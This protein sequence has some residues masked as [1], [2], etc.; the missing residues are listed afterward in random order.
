MT[1]IIKTYLI[2]LLLFSSLFSFAQED[3]NEKLALQ[4]Y[5]NQEFEK[6]AELY[7]QLFEDNNKAYYY[8]NY[9]N[10]L[11][12]LKDFSTAEKF[13][14]KLK[15]KTGNIKYYVDLG[16]IYKKQGKKRKA[17]KEFEEALDDVRPVKYEFVLL[18]NTF[19][20]RGLDN[21]AIKTYEKAKKK[22]KDPLLNIDL[23]NL[24]LSMGEYEL[25][26]EEY[27]SLI[28]ENN[29]YITTVRKKFSLILS[30]AG[31][32]KLDKAI[33]SSL[34]KKIDKNPNKT[35]FSELLYWYSIQ[36]KDFKIALIQAKSLD[37]QFKEEGQRVFSL[38]NTLISNKN[39]ELA[40]Q[41]LEY[42]VDLGKRNKY[43]QSAELKLLDVEFK[44]IENTGIYKKEKVNELIEKHKTKLQN[45]GKNANTLNIIMNLA[46]LYSFYSNDNQ[47]A[48]SLLKEVQ[49]MPRVRPDNKAKAKIL[50]ADIMM[51]IGQKWEA[52]LLYKQVEKAHKND[53]LGSEARFKTAKFFYYVGEM[54]W[55]K[56]QLDVL[57]SIPDKL[58]ANDALELALLIQENIN[59]DSTYDALNMYSK[60]ELFVY[61]NKYDKAF[62]KL[63][64]L[65]YLFPTHQIKDDAYYQKALIYYKMKDYKK[66]DSLF[67][68]VVKLDPQGIKSDDAQIRRARIN[69]EIFND[70]Q[71][72]K[73]LYKSIILDY[74][75][76]IYLSEARR[77]F[78]EM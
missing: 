71:K 8:T 26:V 52:S 22:L 6:A 41:A 78:R 5:Q 19:H 57:K 40:Q 3:V 18:A 70:N 20:N 2:F 14:K 68:E 25:M 77:R 72:A 12:E 64:S 76:S 7:Y 46:K 9:L 4:Y 65:I 67:A 49:N 13:V 15:R 29:R 47:K 11:F 42:I 1:K 16:F 33:K 10:C 36:K 17:E 45:Y 21:Y 51:F 73:E 32:D 28:D 54:E 69:D 43:Y 23:A 53:V 35:V 74:N 34:L 61:Q 60:A 59:I 39:Y 27:L 30:E 66:A 24:Y 63:D 44:I 56:A 38:A 48:I 62:E 31:N 50:M 37:R 55:A 75:Y 58:I